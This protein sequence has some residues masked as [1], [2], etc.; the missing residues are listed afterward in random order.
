MRPPHQD[1]GRAQYPPAASQP[2][3]LLAPVPIYAD[4]L[5]QAVLDKEDVARLAPLPD[6]YRSDRIE[7]AGG[8]ERQPGFQTASGRGMGRVN[9]VVA[10]RICLEGSSAES[11]GR[12]EDW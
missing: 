5:G 11:V 1:E 10:Y 12:M 6:Q 7:L 3:D 4:E 8:Q 2:K 9:A